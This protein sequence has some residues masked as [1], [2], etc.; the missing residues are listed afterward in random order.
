MNEYFAGTR[1]TFSVALDFV[2]TDFQK[3]VWKALLTIP[4]GETRSYKEIAKQVGNERAMRAVGAA[5][6]K[7]PYFYYCA[8]SS[9]YRSIRRAHRICWRFRKEGSTFK[10]GKAVPS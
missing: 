5:S 3:S 1:K 4:Y 2:G 7:N 8:L 9:S 10:S 6:G